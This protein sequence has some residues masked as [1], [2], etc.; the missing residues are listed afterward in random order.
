MFQDYIS[1][2]A[3]ESGGSVFTQES[4]HNEYKNSKNAASIFG[5]VVASSAQPNDCQVIDDYY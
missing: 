1:T 4:L 3:S 2:L 5:R